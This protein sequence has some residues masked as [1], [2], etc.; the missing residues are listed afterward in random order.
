MTKCIIMAI[1]AATLTASF[2]TADALTALR[3]SAGLTSLTAEQIAKYDMDGDGKVTTADVL[4]ILRKAAMIV[5]S[6][7]LTVDSE[8]LTAEA[9]LKIRENY[10]AFN[11]GTWRG[12]A[13][14]AE[15]LEIM[16]YFG[17]FGGREAVVI[18]PKQYAMTADMQY[19]EIAGYTIA[20]GS[21]SLQL[22]VHDNG[23]FVPI[24]E[25]YEQGLLTAEDIRIIAGE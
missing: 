14:T 6:G 24:R 1:I 10:L 17:T 18:F 21:G 15:D 3:A 16:Y 23:K 25:A 19:I 11:G 13:M 9:D 4:L 5:D 20:L 7:E 8:E 2:T 22:V 12:T